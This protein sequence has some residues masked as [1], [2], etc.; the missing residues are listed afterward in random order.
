MNPAEGDVEDDV[1]RGGRVRGTD[2]GLIVSRRR[3]MFFTRSRGISIYLIQL[4]VVSSASRP[5]L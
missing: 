3:G 2:C 5:L 4:L 1:R